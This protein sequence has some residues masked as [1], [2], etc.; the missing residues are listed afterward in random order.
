M[1]LQEFPTFVCTVPYARVNCS[2]AKNLQACD[3]TDNIIIQ[4]HVLLY[5][6]PNGWKSRVWS[7]KNQIWNIRLYN[8]TKIIDTSWIDTVYN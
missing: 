7:I 3:A 4:A 5:R 6:Q 1:Y 2:T 8:T